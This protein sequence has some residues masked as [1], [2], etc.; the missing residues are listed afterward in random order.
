MRHLIYRGRV[1]RIGSSLAV[2]VAQASDLNASPVTNELMMEL[3]E[4][5]SRE[6]QHGRSPVRKETVSRIDVRFQL[7][8]FGACQRIRV[9]EPNSL[10]LTKACGQR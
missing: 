7:R 2:S 8:L 1:D 5:L 9:D 10:V 3:S 6:S 4:E